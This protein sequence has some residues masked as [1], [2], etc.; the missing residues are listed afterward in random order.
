ADVDHRAAGRQ[1]RVDL[2]LIRLKLTFPNAIKIY[3][4]PL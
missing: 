1:M 2:L 3:S 4:S